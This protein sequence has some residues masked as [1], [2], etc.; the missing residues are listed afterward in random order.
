LFGAGLEV[1]A[2]E[3]FHSAE[4]FAL[5]SLFGAFS[6]LFFFVSC[7]LLQEDLFEAFFAAGGLEFA[8]RGEG[9]VGFVF[10]DF[11]YGLSGLGRFTRDRGFGEVGAGDLEG[12]EQQ[13]GAA[14]VDLVGGEAADDLAEVELD[15]GAVVGF[16]QG[17]GGLAAGPVLGFAFEDCASGLMVVVA[18]VLVAERG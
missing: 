15:G 6:G 3:E 9:A 14:G 10:D 18:E 11:V 4:L 5:G 12:V 8:L 17:E 7:P 16:E 1:E 2:L 13:T